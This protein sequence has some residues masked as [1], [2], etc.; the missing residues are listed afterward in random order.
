MIRLFG[1]KRARWD[2]LNRQIGTEGEGGWT[3]M[4]PPLRWPDDGREY[5]IIVWK[6]WKKAPG[7]SGGTTHGKRGR[8][9]M[10]GIQRQGGP[11]ATESA[12]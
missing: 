5:R 4:V 7:P 2:L 9:W 1:L 6:K 12:T 11:A 10:M 3:I 8:L